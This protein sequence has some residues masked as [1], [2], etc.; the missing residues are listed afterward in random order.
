MK[1]ARL[2]HLGPGGDVHMVDVSAKPITTREARARGTVRMTAQALRAIVEGNLPKG[3]VMTTARIAG[4]QAAK[5]T[6]ELIPMCHPLALSLVDVDCT[7]NE[8]TPG[9]DVTSLVRCQG[10]TGAEMEALTAVAAAALTIIDMA[11]SADR[12]MTIEGITLIEKRGGKS[13][14]QRRPKE[15]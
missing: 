5:R 15:R 8:R 9:V 11:K 1:A 3:D 7:P 14:T 13:G 6:S 2:T 10:Q 12:W 4:I